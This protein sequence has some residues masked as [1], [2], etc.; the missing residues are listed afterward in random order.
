MMKKSEMKRIENAASRQVTFS[1]RRNGL[2]KKAYEL[3]V[4]CDAEVALFVFSPSGKLYE[5][6]SSS[7]MDNTIERY[8]ITYDKAEEIGKKTK[9]EIIQVWILLIFLIHSITKYDT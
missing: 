1:K 6:S 4:L 8:A 7:V 3:S 2:S 5:Y 9:E